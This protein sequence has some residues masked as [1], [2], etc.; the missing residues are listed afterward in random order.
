MV[1]YAPELTLRDARQQ[2]FDRA[3]FVDG[4]YSDRWV[5]LK[6]GP[7][8]FYFPN[9]ESRKRS[10]KLHDLHHVLTGYETTWTGE[11]EIAA[12]EIASGCGRHVPAWVLNAGALAIGVVIAPLRTW[13]AFLRG[14][15]S[16]N[17]YPGVFT[18]DL[19]DR[20]V[21]EMRRE[22]A[23][24]A[25]IPAASFADRVAFVLWIIVCVAAWML[26]WALLLAALAFVVRR[27]ASFV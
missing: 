11:S 15:H 4:G 5:R 19:L 13:R 27:A 3:G 2:Y 23:L 18:E 8:V 22:L 6:A 1:H 25:P 12:W 9:T 26:P 21:G 17:L 14:R 24:D 10:V 7:L 20:V 16:A